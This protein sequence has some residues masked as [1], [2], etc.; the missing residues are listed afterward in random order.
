[1][2]RIFEILIS[3]CL[4]LSLSITLCGC[5]D[6]MIETG[7]PIYHHVYVDKYPIYI[8]PTP[9]PPPHYKPIPRVYSKPRPMFVPNKSP[10]N[11]NR[12]GHFGN[13]QRR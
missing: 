2:K 12:K 10:M 4:L 9:P 3:I 11:N 8:H 1:M 6:M 5:T 7:S 13:G